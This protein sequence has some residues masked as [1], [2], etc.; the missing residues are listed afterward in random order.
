MDTLESCLINLLLRQKAANEQYAKI[1]QKQGL[2][3]N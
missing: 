3:K 2:Y 1:I